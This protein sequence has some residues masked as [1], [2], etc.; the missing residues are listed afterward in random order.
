MALG[1]VCSVWETKR[2]SSV[3]VFQNEDPKR[4]HTKLEENWPNTGTIR[5]IFHPDNA[6]TNSVSKT[7][8]LV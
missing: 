8:D 3:W 2:Q 4:S 5:N 1:C 7:K 6:S